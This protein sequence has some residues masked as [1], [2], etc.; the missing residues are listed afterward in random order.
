MKRNLKIKQ[1]HPESDEE[2]PDILEFWELDSSTLPPDHKYKW[3]R[4][5]GPYLEM[6]QWHWLH[7][8]YF[9]IDPDAEELERLR[10]I[11]LKTGDKNV[12]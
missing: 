11:V 10:D 12:L 7:E 6:Y 1:I 5:Q 2:V 3:V 4:T 8:K 9:Y